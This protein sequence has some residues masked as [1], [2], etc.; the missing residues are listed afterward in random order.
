MNIVISVLNQRIQDVEGSQVPSKKDGEFSVT[1]MVD[2]VRYDWHFVLRLVF[3]IHMSREISDP[4]ADIKSFGVVFRT[5]LN[6]N[7]CMAEKKKQ[8]Q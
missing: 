3:L 8:Q 1:L 2:V 4:F 5:I 6:V 7:V